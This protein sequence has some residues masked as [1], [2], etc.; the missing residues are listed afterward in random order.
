[1]ADKDK[2]AMWAKKQKAS[3]ISSSGYVHSTEFQA[4]KPCL[5]R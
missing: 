5:P 3:K 2:A 4:A 1:L